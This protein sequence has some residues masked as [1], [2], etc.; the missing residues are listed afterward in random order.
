MVAGVHVKGNLTLAEDLADTGG[1]RLAWSALTRAN[2]GPVDKKTSQLFFESF[3][4]V[5]LSSVHGLSFYFSFYI[6][7]SFALDAQL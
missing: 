5:T 6:R 3:A 1:L 4:Q 2:G 7:S